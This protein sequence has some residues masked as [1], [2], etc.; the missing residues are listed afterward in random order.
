MK[1]VILGLVF[2]FGSP[3]I[4]TA[5]TTIEYNVIDTVRIVKLT[6][7]YKGKGE[8]MIARATEDLRNQITNIC[9]QNSQILDASL[10]K[11]E[12]DNSSQRN[13]NLNFWHSCLGICK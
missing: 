3:M 6:N 8:D 12:A 13:S 11:C 7:E 2:I 4:A 10:F 5:T 9:R 1:F